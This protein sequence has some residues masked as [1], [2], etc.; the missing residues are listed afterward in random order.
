VSTGIPRAIAWVKRQLADDQ[1]AFEALSPEW[2]AGINTEWAG[3]LTEV[4]AVL[5]AAE[6]E[7]GAEERV[8]AVAAIQSAGGSGSRCTQ[9]AWSKTLGQMGG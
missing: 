3:V 9:F 5:Q 7:P 1:E 2:R 6:G 8:R 4:L